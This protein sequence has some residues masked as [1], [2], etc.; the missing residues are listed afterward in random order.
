LSSRAAFRLPPSACRLPL[1][2]CRLQL[3]AFRLSP[4]AWPSQAEGLADN[5]GY[6]FLAHNGG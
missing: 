2:A 3:A 5:G 4:A 6:R 1:A